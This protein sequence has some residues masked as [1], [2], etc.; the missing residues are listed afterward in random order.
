MMI[1]ILV[2]FLFQG[3]LVQNADTSGYKNEF[4]HISEVLLK[5]S[6]KRDLLPRGLQ[7]KQAESFSIGETKPFFIRNLSKTN[8]WKTRTYELLYESPKSRIWI[9]VVDFSYVTERQTITTIRDS[10]ATFL[11]SA[12]MAHSINPQKGILELVS[13]IY[14]EIPDPDSDGKIDI[15]LL[16]ILEPLGVQ[17]TIAGYFDPID[18]ADHPNSNRADII[19]IDIYPLIYLSPLS[20]SVSVDL[21][22]GTISHELQHLILQGYKGNE[23]EETFINEGLSELSEILC[24]FSPRLAEGFFSSPF[25]PFFSWNY[26]SALSDYSRA[27]LWFH[28]LYEQ[29]GYAWIKPYVQQSQV[30][31]TYHISTLKN[32]NFV[33]LDEWKLWTLS[34]LN[35][36]KEAAQSI[37]RD[38]R[39]QNL[40]GINPKA[41]KTGYHTFTNGDFQFR[42]QSTSSLKEMDLESNTRS[43]IQIY[44]ELEDGNKTQNNLKAGA[45]EK[46]TWSDAAYVEW[47]QFWESRSDTVANS[48]S[49]YLEESKAELIQHVGDG[50]LTS[51]SMFASRITLNGNTQKIGL[52]F[53][54]QNMQRITGVGFS[55]L[56]ETEFRGNNVETLAPRV[57]NLAIYPIKNG[58]IEQVPIYKWENRVS[59]RE[60]GNAA[61]EWIPFE[62]EFVPA[63]KN[64]SEVFIELSSASAE[65]EL[66]VGMQAQGTSS[67]WITS[68]IWQSQVEQNTSIQSLSF[69]GFP[70]ASEFLPLIALKHK[71]DIPEFSVQIVASRDKQM[72]QLILDSPQLQR[73]LNKQ[74][75]IKKPDGS[76]FTPRFKNEYSLEIEPFELSEEGRYEAILEFSKGNFSYLKRQDWYFPKEKSFVL[77]SLY[78]NPFNPSTTIEL[79]LLARA[80]NIEIIVFDILGRRVR[81]QNYSGFEAG[82]HQVSVQLNGLASG[83]YF[84]KLELTDDTGRKEI[85]NSKGLLIK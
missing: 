45:N 61:L 71:A 16:N 84:F 48:S 65:N 23:V 44:T 77:N 68:G 35:R 21:A 9:D 47:V 6:P 52:V 32:K 63:A 53:P 82:I 39:R 49:I 5:E 34:W 31:I 29:M 80:T 50:K 24:G 78:P 72:I 22:A 62:E 10:L 36:E 55:G 13:S 46:V 59:R 12:T 3:L 70:L 38:E 4:L 20:S 28:Y 43:E 67:G 81:Q 19:Y 7:K 54:V 1:Y 60:M 83:L 73:G 58:R 11:N 57:Y 40:G 51:F 37:Y 33:F 30:G 42:Y 74:F 14:G 15:L 25:R 18:L 76:L 27:S 41:L 66:S 26:S 85:L 2:L 8:A 17:G 69:Y 75:V 56:F 64:I 79:S